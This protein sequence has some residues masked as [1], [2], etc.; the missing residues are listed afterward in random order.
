MLF[1]VRTRKAASL[2]EL[3]RLVL[4]HIYDIK[5]MSLAEEDLMKR[6]FINWNNKIDI[7]PWEKILICKFAKLIKDDEDG[8]FEK[9]KLLFKEK[10]IDYKKFHRLPESYD[11]KEL[12]KT[13]EKLRGTAS[14][15]N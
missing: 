5:N 4:K 9:R 12:I 2:Q 7:H 11:M 6:S 8:K 14:G 3:I 13:R 15:S 10:N 1:K